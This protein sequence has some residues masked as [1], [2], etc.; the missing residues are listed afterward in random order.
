MYFRGV[1]QALISLRMEGVTNPIKSWHG[2]CCK[3][4]TERLLTAHFIPLNPIIPRRNF[5]V[6]WLEPGELS[7]VLPLS[8]VH[9]WRR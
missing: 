3:Q 2:F 7:T 6:F 8:A 9:V 1:S 4:R 5:S